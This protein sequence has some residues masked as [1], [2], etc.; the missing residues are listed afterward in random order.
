MHGQYIP[1]PADGVERQSIDRLTPDADN[2]R[3]HSEAKLDE[4]PPR[5]AAEDRQCRCW[6]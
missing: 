4:T 1:R 5:S 6:P 3:L 2:S